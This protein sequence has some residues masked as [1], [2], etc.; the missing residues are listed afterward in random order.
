MYVPAQMMDVKKAKT[1]QFSLKLEGM[2]VNL[3][4]LTHEYCIKTK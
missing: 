4:V 2:R 3:L 1:L